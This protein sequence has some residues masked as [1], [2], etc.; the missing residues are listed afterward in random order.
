MNENINMT[1]SVVKIKQI[2]NEISQ[3]LGVDV[4]TFYSADNAKE[5]LQLVASTGLNQKAVGFSLSYN[6]GLTGKVARD[7]KTL[8]ARDPQNHPDFYYVPGSEEERFNS[9]LGIPLLHQQELIGVL[10]IQRVS[11][12]MFR[13][14]DIKSLFTAGRGLMDQLL[15]M[16]ENV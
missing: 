13:H 15:L 2:L 6:Q 16:N 10:V 14:S 12:T 8:S 9:Y 1:D 3:E 11:T 7:R 5:E 4:S